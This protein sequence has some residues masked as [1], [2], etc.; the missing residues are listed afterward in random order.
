MYTLVRVYNVQ[1]ISAQFRG[2]VIM[3]DYH[4]HRSMFD[5]FTM[6]ACPFIYPII[7]QDNAIAK[8]HIEGDNYQKGITKPFVQVHYFLYIHLPLISIIGQCLCWGKWERAKVN[9]NCLHIYID[10]RSN[11]L[12]MY[13]SITGLTC[14]YILYTRRINYWS[15]IKGL[16]VWL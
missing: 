6:S 1:I 11:Q 8:F 13:K 7:N 14:T 5:I 3:T 2:A 15:M 12:I 10:K 16:Q 9:E 4:L